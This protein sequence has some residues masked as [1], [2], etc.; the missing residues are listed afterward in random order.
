MTPAEKAVLND[1]LCGVTSD[2]VPLDAATRERMLKSI[3]PNAMLSDH[4]ADLAEAYYVLCAALGWTFVM[5]S[6]Y[7]RFDILR[8]ARHLAET[9]GGPYGR[10]TFSE[11]E[12]AQ[13]RGVFLPAETP[14]GASTPQPP[15]ETP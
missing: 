9:R 14:T 6:V 5:D 15:V 1:V 12:I 4:A 7:P 10:L 2:G 13:V 8:A 3:E 11:Q